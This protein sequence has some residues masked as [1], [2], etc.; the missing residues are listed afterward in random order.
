MEDQ[1]L[2]LVGDKFA[3]FASLNDGVT[4][5]S[6]LRTLRHRQNEKGE[7]ARI[8]IG[9]GVDLNSLKDVVCQ[10]GYF[11][12]PF[13]SPNAHHD[14]LHQRTVHKN[15]G[16][17][18]LIAPPRRIGETEFRSSLHLHD[19]CAELSDH[20]TGQHLQGMIFIEAAR[21]MMLSASENYLIPEEFRFAS[22]FVLNEIRTS[23]LAFAFPIE[24]EILFDLEA[25]EAKT[26][27]NLRATCISRFIQAGLPVA[28]VDIDFC[29]YPRE[30]L[31]RKESKLAA[32]AIR[33]FIDAHIDVNTPA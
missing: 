28:R 27:G 32:E 23:F 4:T 19:D 8:L 31:E 17:N 30:H 12:E 25:F 6:T 33:R 9:Q 10:P 20:V 16:H 24:T 5:I 22:Y 26:N 29:A 11:E 3:N 14:Q 18:V 15:H 7:S 21:Q 13:E 1:T 2:L